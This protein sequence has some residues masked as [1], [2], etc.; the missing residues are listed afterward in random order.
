MSVP[1]P[2]SVL[3][4]WL[5]GARPAVVGHR[6]AAAH[7]PENTLASFRAALGAD[8]VE[9]D[10][11]LSSDQTLFL[12]HDDSL[13]RTTDGGA[14]GLDLARPASAQPWE[15]LQTLD[16]GSWFD[17]AWTGER[18][19]LL[20]DLAALLS[21]ALDA[22][23]PVG[24]D[25]EIKSP[26]AHAARTVVAAVAAAL[27]ADPW[28]QLVEAHTVMVTSF[29]PEVVELGCELLPVPVGLLTATTPPAEN[30][31]ELADLGLAALVTSHDDL[32][33]PVVTA[34]HEA[35]L[36][37]GVYTANEPADWDRLVGL[38]VDFIVSDDP[39]ALSAHL[40]R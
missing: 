17:G 35:G 4:F 33:E 23:A 29:D 12:L 26:T 15:T 8:A 19:A 34:A 31:A 24:L 30:V 11:Q 10:V 27:R 21:R 28:Q 36:V 37:V 7:A 1:R 25:L 16:A 39:V 13:E 14:H 2:P 32:T 22:G 6:G 38:D 5:S 3:P 18:L 20:D 9:T 40:G